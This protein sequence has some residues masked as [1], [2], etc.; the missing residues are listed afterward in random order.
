[1]LLGQKYCTIRSQKRIFSSLFPQAPKKQQK[2]KQKQ[3]KNNNNNKNNK[4]RITDI[5]GGGPIGNTW[6][7]LRLFSG[8]S[9]VILR[10]FSGS[11]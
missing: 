5:L 3:T 2:Q 4:N 1:V 6:K 8:Y 9:Q 11:S 10:F 7:V